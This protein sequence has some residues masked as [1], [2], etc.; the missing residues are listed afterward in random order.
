MAV[1]P[2]RH[3]AKPARGDLRAGRRCY[4]HMA[5]EVGITLYD[6]FAA[7][8]W[9]VVD[10]AGRLGDVKLTAKGILGFAALGLDIGSLRGQRRRFAYGCVDWQEGKRHV[11]GA[12]GAALTRLALGRQWVVGG[13]ASRELHLTKLGRRELLGPIASRGSLG[14]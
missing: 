12:L 2:A 1:A 4:D 3:P 7:L 11:G 5:G 10:R 9:L 8:G 13:R 6:G 14:P